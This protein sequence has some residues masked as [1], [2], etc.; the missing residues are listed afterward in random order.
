MHSEVIGIVCDSCMLL[1]NGAN[2]D[3]TENEIKSFEVGCALLGNH[4]HTGEEIGFLWQKCTVCEQNTGGNR[5]ELIQLSEIATN[6][7]SN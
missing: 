6:D 1:M 2:D 3:A 7:T 5:H 4:L